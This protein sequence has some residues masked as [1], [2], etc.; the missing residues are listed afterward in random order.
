MV[1]NGCVA[2]TEPFEGMMR[3]DHFTFDFIDMIEMI[4]IIDVIVIV[5]R[6]SEEAWR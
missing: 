1:F 6:Y 2:R 4:D 5:G 3:A